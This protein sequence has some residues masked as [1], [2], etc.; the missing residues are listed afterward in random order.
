MAIAGITAGLNPFQSMRR[1]TGTSPLDQQNASAKL[2][3]M[4]RQIDQMLSS[5]IAH[6]ANMQDIRVLRM[7]LMQDLQA[8]GAQGVSTKASGRVEQ[9]INRKLDEL[10]RQ[11]EQLSLSGAANSAPHHAVRATQPLVLAPDQN[12]VKAAGQPSSFQLS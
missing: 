4:K 3:R 5:A 8:A 2:D 12:L 6:G 1:V 7:Q 10:K 9:E 11:I